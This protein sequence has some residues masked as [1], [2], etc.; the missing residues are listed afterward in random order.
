MH[1]RLLRHKVSPHT[2]TILTFAQY[3]MESGRALA[4]HAH[5]RVVGLR[6]TAPSVV[7][8]AIVDV[9]DLRCVL[10]HGYV[11]SVSLLV[12]GVQTDVLGGGVVARGTQGTR[13]AVAGVVWVGCRKRKMGINES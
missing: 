2:T 7:A 12:R 10:H 3:S 13:V 4:S 6:H 1:K 9:A 11:T 5:H 8:T